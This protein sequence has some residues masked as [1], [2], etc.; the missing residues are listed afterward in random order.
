MKSK[1]NTKVNNAF[2]KVDV[3]TWNPEIHLGFLPRNSF[4]KEIKNTSAW[5]QQIF[6]INHAKITTQRTFNNTFSI[7]GHDSKIEWSLDFNYHYYDTN[8]TNFGVPDLGMF[9]KYDFSDKISFSVNGESMLSLF[10]LNNFNSLHT[11]FDGNIISR[12]TTK[13]NLGYLL[14]NVHLKL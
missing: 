5:N 7:R 13:D 2:S 10:K 4:V 11:Q 8:D 9:L 14:F 1:Y 3:T 6:R 12:T